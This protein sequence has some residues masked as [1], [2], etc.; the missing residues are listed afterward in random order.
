MT[1]EIEAG[2]AAEELTA[3]E[4]NWII[5]AVNCRKSAE[6]ARLK[7]QAELNY[8]KMI[9]DEAQGYFDRGGVWPIFDLWELD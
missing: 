2:T 8:Y 4:K 9:W 1:T 5:S 6:D 3:R 7:T